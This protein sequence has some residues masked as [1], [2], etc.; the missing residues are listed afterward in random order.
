MRVGRLLAAAAIATLLTMSCDPK[1]QQSDV[2]RSPEPQLEPG[3]ARI[4][5]LERKVL[6][7]KKEVSRRLSLKSF[8]QEGPTIPGTLLAIPRIGAMTWRCNEQKALAVTFRPAGAT[9]TI[10]YGPNGEFAQRKVL[11]P[12]DSFTTPFVEPDQAHVFAI[13]HRHKPGLI[14][15]RIEVRPRL[16]KYSCFVGRIQV[17]Q[18]ARVFE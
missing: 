9:V 16:S 17:D 18:S 14:R 12:G 10:R 4:G 2:E 13:R 6:R 5:E 15:T 8:L 11:N 3:E 1:P 7:L